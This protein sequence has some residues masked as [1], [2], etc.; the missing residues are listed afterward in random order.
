MASYNYNG[1]SPAASALTNL[2]DELD[3]LDFCIED[4]YYSIDSAEDYGCEDSATVI[5]VALREYEA[6]RDALRAEVRRLS[7]HVASEEALE[8]ALEDYTPSH[9]SQ[10]RDKANAIVSARRSLSKWKRECMAD[11]E[12]GE[13]TCTIGHAKTLNWGAHSS[14]VKRQGRKAYRAAVKH[15]MRRGDFDYIPAPR[16]TERDFS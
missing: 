14:N 10:G 3:T 11:I 16:S 7:L 13:G 6:R 5:L 9:G 12:A 2:L 8:L 1:A 15:A 4:C